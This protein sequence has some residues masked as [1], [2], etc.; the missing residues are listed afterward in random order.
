MLFSEE[1]MVNISLWEQLRLESNWHNQ[2][3]QG[4]AFILLGLFDHPQVVY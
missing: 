2:K 1:Q 4:G 3:A